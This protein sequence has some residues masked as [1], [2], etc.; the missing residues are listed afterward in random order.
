MHIV[1]LIAG[2]ADAR[3]NLVRPATGEWLDLLDEPTT[4]L[5]LS[6]FDEAALENALQL[7][8]RNIATTITAIVTDGAV[9]ETL[10]RAVAAYRLDN[11]TGLCAPTRMRGNPL[12]LASNIQNML[13]TADKPVDLVLIG[14]EHGDLDDG[15]V[16][17]YVAEYCGWSFVGLATRIQGVEDN[18]WC[19]ERVANNTDELLQVA[20]PTFV[21][22]NNDK[23]N[24]LRHPLMKN[25]ML[26]K[27]QKTPVIRPDKTEVTGSADVTQMAP[28]DVMIR[29]D[30]PCEMLEGSL[31]QQADQLVGCLIKW[32]GDAP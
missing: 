19:I 11:V 4:P 31:E 7:R 27:K 8:D 23:S 32:Q 26:A 21:S 28:V 14:R 17:A 9:D 22:I 13:Q 18:H 20:L 5:K 10:M 12:W 15:M 29:G 25:V 30:A 6:P 2:I 3:Q 24:R 16:P 1:V